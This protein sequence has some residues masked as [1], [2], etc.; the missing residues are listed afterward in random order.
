MQNLSGIFWG[1]SSQ[2][3]S[4]FSIRFTQGLRGMV[5]SALCYGNGW[6][7][8]WIVWS[9]RAGTGIY[10]FMAEIVEC[11]L[12]QLDF[13][14]A[15]DILHYIGKLLKIKLS[16]VTTFFMLMYCCITSLTFLNNHSCN[17]VQIEFCSAPIKLFEMLNIS[18]N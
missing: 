16:W 13:I 12:E 11:W 9:S 1:A 7:R 6:I 18:V 4:H 17:W 14:P 3:D 15:T 2:I 8:H 5:Q 10:H